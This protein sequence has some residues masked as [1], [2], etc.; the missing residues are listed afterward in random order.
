MDISKRVAV[1]IPAA[2]AEI[3]TADGSHVVIHD[4]DL[5]MVG[6]NLNRIYEKYSNE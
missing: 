2:I 1:C 6:P 5:F 4:H 3:D